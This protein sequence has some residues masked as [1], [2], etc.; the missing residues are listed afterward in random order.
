MDPN[1]E[2]FCASKGC[3]I[4]YQFG[5]DIGCDPMTEDFEKC[6]GCVRSYAVSNG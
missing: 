5:E 3:E 4:V 1:A 2:D 6:Q